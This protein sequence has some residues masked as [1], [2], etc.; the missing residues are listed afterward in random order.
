VEV[1]REIAR[2]VR[3]GGVF[4]F[5]DSLQ[6]GDA[7]DLDQMLEFFPVGF[8]EPYYGS[9]LSTDLVALFEEAGFAHEETELAFLT[10]ILRLRR[11]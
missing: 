9:Y 6:L 10:K 4:V 2:I 1:A 8:H 11:K 3:P 7:P 5:A